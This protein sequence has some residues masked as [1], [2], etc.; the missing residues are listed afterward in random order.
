MD[1][2]LVLAGLLLSVCLKFVRRLRLRQQVILWGTPF[3]PSI[4]YLRSQ[5]ALGE[6]AGVC[7][8]GGLE[9]RLHAA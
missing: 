9:A 3:G 6:D 8:G 7:F 5:N 4:V 2:I 1:Q